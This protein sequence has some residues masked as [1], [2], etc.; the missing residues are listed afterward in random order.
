MK[1]KDVYII[2]NKVNNEILLVSPDQG[3]IDED[4]PIVND[5]R[6]KDENGKFVY[7]YAKKKDEVIAPTPKKRIVKSRLDIVNDD[8]EIDKHF[9][10]VCRLDDILHTSLKGISD[11]DLRSDEF[12]KKICVEV[13]KNYNNVLNGESYEK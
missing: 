4:M 11:K 9:D 12:Y 8:G 7:Y 10:F 5:L 6:N 13:E 1:I 2:L 3:S